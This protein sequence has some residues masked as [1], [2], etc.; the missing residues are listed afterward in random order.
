MGVVRHLLFLLAIFIPSTAFVFLVL[1]LLF[2]L[3]IFIP[4]IAVAFF[5]TSHEVNKDVYRQTSIRPDWAAKRPPDRQAQILDQQGAADR[6]AQIGLP[7]GLQIG[8]PT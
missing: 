6:R 7:S 8:R 4:S 3:A 1:H 2:L 5:L